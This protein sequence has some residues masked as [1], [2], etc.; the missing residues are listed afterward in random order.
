[1]SSITASSS[2]SSTISSWD[3]LSFCSTSS[4]EAFSSSTETFSSSTETFSSSTGAK[5]NLTSSSS[6]SVKPD[7]AVFTSIPSSLAW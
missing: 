4:T 1:M 5:A 2:C 6:S 3:S 7:E